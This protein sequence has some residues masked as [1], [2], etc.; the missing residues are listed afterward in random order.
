MWDDNSFGCTVKVMVVGKNLT[1]GIKVT[2]SIEVANILFLF[3]INAN[4]RIAIGLVNTNEPG[5]VL[6]LFISVR[7][8]FHA[9][10]LL[11]FSF[12]EMVF[13]QQFSDYRLADAD[14]VLLK[15]FL[16]NLSMSEMGPPNLWVARISSG[17]VFDDI[18]EG[19]V[20]IRV[21]FVIWFATTTRVANTR[22]VIQL[23]SF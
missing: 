19:F 7:N 1:G 17:V 9:L 2:V 18:K 14:A 10:F 11:S 6:E 8:L 20:D 21:D 13:F 5:N 12:L 4:N 23:K 3:C 22:R 15:K 16:S